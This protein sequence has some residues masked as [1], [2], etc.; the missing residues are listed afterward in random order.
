MKSL[1]TIDRMAFCLGSIK[2]L[3]TDFVRNVETLGVKN[4]T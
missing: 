1:S 2:F 3:F 4:I